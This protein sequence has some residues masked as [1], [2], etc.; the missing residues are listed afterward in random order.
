LIAII[1]LVVCAVG[2]SSALSSPPSDAFRF[3]YDADGRL[4]AAIDPEGDTATYNWD[5]A[6]NLLSIG[7]SASS[8]LTV[9]QLSPSQGEVS[10]AGFHGDSETRILSWGMEILRSHGTKEEVPRGVA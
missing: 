10:Q 8:K 5:A 2:P 9:L 3:V 7:R 4:K 6:G 1:T